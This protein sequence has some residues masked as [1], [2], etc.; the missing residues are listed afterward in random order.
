MVKIVAAMTAL[1]KVYDCMLRTTGSSDGTGVPFDWAVP[2]VFGLICEL[3][4]LGPNYLDGP[5]ARINA[6]QLIC[7]C[8]AS[9]MEGSTENCLP[10]PSTGPTI[11]LGSVPRRPRE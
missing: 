11:A 4:S 1:V 2:C 9:G 5:D 8:A 10:Q 7:N 3:M 6:F